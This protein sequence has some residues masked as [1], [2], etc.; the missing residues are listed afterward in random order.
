MQAMCVAAPPLLL[1][2]TQP[3]LVAAKQKF[4]MLAVEW[5]VLTLDVAT[6]KVSFGSV[7]YPPWVKNWPRLEM[8]CAVKAKANNLDVR[9]SISAA[10][11]E[12][13]KL[14]RLDPKLAR[15]PV[16]TGTR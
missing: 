15:V 6:A 3:V 2:F 11:L 7:E 9:V 4:P 16:G 10:L 14:A 1:K 8:Y 12:A 13:V 5:K